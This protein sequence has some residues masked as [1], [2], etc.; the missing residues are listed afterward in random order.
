MP[1]Q[2][3]FSEFDPR[4]FE[5]LCRDLL[6]RRITEELG[7]PF[8][9]N[10]PKE[11]ADTGADGFFENKKQKIVLQCKR[12]SDF[13]NLYSEL[14]YSELPKVIKLNPTR[15]II[16]TSCK[17]SKKEIDKIYT[18]FKSYVQDINDILGQAMIN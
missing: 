8:F 14:T 17:L 1:S 10:S 18:L 15:Y 16:A 7:K 4:E 3:T 2:Y 5:F 13:K 11:G 6:Q 12:Y 9:F